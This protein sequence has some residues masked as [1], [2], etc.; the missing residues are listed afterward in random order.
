MLM[1]LYSDPVSHISHR[2][3]IA[4]QEKQITVNKVDIPASKRSRRNELPDDFLEDVLGGAMTSG[5]LAD[6][7]NEVLPALVDRK[8]TLYSV[9]ALLEYIDERFP[10]PLLL[11]GHPNDRARCRMWMHTFE[12]EVTPDVARLITSKP[13]QMVRTK[14]RK[15]LVAKLSLFSQRMSGFEFVLGA[16]TGSRECDEFS[17]ADCYL[18]P[19]LW[20]LK[21]MKVVLPTNKNTL[22]IL[23]YFR[24]MLMRDSLRYSL[25]NEEIKMRPELEEAVTSIQKQR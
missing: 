18:L 19:V 24:R 20:R 13:A 15:S 17:L 10:H 7:L 3:R 23:D 2:L 4:L 11:P 9:Q 12:K 1:K 6:D 22:P 25:S 5:N 14:A 16:I 21:S 8:V